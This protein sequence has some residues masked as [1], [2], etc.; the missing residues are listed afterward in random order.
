EDA[1]GGELFADFDGGIDAALDGHAQVHQGEV[2]VAFGEEFER[3]RT[4]GGFGDDF[5]VRFGVHERGQTHAHNEMVV[6]NQDS[7]FAFF[8]HDSED[9]GSE[10]GGAGA[11]A[12]GISARTT[13][14][15]PGALVKVTLPPSRLAR[16]EM[17][18]SPKWPSR[19]FELAVPFG[20][21]PWPLSST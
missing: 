16:S 12:R 8:L 20:T 3:L 5:H 4:I 7:D 17:P 11:G 13:A 21:K 2:G 9:A 19:P 6:G 1:S 15:F 10:T 14:P 18:S